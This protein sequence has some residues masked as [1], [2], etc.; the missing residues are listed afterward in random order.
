MQ[1]TSDKYIAQLVLMMER[2]R[3][4]RWAHEGGPIGNAIGPA[5][6]DALRAAIRNKKYVCPIEEMPSV[7]SKAVK[8]TSL[9]A[10]AAAGMIYLPINRPWAERLVSQLLAFPA[11]RWDDAA[12]TAGLLGRLVD[13]MMDA[14]DDRPEKRP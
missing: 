5:I 14:K 8:L 12:D 6:R 3:P 10:K 4:R 7:K 9:Q 1:T 13:Q 11:G 2:N